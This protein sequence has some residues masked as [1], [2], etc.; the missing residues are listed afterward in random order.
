VLSDTEKKDVRI[1]KYC[2]KQLL[3][4]KRMIGF[5]GSLSSTAK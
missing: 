5:T 1:F 2:G 3:D 4:A